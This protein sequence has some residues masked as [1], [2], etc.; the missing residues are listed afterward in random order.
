[1][2]P[3]LRMPRQIERL[4]GPTRTKLLLQALIATMLLVGIGV[5]GILTDRA[6]QQAG[7][8]QT[9]TAARMSDHAQVIYQALAAADT[10]ATGRLLAKDEVARRT[11][12]SDYTAA[13]DQIRQQLGSAAG[14]TGGNPGRAADVARVALQLP[15][16]T[17][18]VEKA[19]NLLAHATSS[20]GP[21]LLGSAYLREASN[22]LRTV[23]L[24]AADQLWND[25]VRRLADAQNRVRW[26][27]SIHLGVLL[28][29]LGVLAWIQWSLARRTHRI[30]N[31][32]LLAA[33]VLLAITLGATLWSLRGWPSA[34]R[35]LADVKRNISLQQARVSDLRA[36]LAANADTY[37][38]LD[39]TSSRNSSEFRKDFRNDAH[40]GSAHP[41]SAVT[42]WCSTYDKLIDGQLLAGKNTAAVRAALPGGGVAQ[43]FNAVYKGKSRTIDQGTAEI[44]LPALRVPPAPR[45]LGSLVVSLSACALIT[46]ALGFRTRL[47]D[48]F[49]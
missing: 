29:G 19:Q 40:C 32:G 5:T 24:H 48:Y 4:L 17:A 21:A 35:E 46:G 36:A 44:M 3:F 15:V 49:L 2:R 38:R 26:T 22:Y 31:V 9:T 34:N 25:E 47:K 10:A 16:Y 7:R 14:L 13:I 23:L 12:D 45:G 11:L 28:A 27:S 8:I 33:T 30:V 18:L 1:V 43:A 6:L 41:N 20:A 37:L 39:G 42:M